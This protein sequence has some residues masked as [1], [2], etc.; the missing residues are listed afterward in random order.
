MRYLFILVFLT[1]LTRLASQTPTNVY[2]FPGLGSDE[3]LFE[4]IKLDSNYKVIPIMYH[5]PARKATMTEY[6]IELIK[7]ID[8]TQKYIFIG[9]SIGGMLCVELA[10]IL[11]PEKVAIISSAKCR[12]ELPFRY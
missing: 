8:T 11:A 1:L 5:V 9:V 7:Q 4:K 2:L 12:S 6:A 10:G 3:R